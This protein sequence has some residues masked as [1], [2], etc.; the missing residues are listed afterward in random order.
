MKVR[1]SWGLGDMGVY[2][3]NDKKCYEAAESRRTCYEA[4][5]SRTC[6]EA[7]LKQEILL[8]VYEEVSGFY[9]SKCLHETAALTG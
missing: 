3:D 9:P 6:Y 8:R 2:I 7:T 5:E 4:A 1:D